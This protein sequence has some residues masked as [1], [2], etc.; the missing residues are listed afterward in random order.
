MNS[1][2]PIFFFVITD[3]SLLQNFE[4]SNKKKFKNINSN[5]QFAKKTKLFY[6]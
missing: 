3:I 1:N 5:K 6:R 2:G 4:N